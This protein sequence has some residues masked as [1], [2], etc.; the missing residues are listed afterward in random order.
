MDIERRRF[1]CLAKTLSGLALP[2]A[3]TRYFKLWKR[4]RNIPQLASGY[5]ACGLAVRRSRLVEVY[6]ANML[7]QTR[8]SA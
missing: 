5:Y 3:H 1:P 7:D 6:T 8:D 2:C 4:E